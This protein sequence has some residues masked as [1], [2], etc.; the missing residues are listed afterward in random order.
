MIHPAYLSNISIVSFLT[1]KWKLP[2][3]ISWIFFWFKILMTNLICYC[4]WIFIYL[5]FL[6]S[7]LLNWFFLNL[8]FLDDEL[9]RL[10]FLSRD[11][12]ELILFGT[13]T[14]IPMLSKH[15]ITYQWPSSSFE[16]FCTSQGKYQSEEIA[17]NTSSKCVHNKILTAL[18]HKKRLIK[19][20]PERPQRRRADI[21]F[22]Y[23]EW[24]Q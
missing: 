8:T 21:F 13:Y 14:N 3:A 4:N 20:W 22:H 10:H 18:V 19:S 1:Q 12:S 11:H 9:L 23:I 15:K 2:V 6:I 7:W 24:Y 16:L 5:R 17:F